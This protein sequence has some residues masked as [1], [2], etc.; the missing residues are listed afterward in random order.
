ME[1]EVYALTVF[2]NALIAG[3]SFGTAGGAPA[4]GIAS[5]NEVSWSPLGSGVEGALSALTVYDGKLIAGGEF[6]TAGTG[7]ARYI[8]SWNGSAWSPLGSGTNDYVGALTVY[9]NGLFVG[10]DFIIAG[11]KVSA[12]LAEWDPDPTGIDIDDAETKGLS[13]RQNYPNP[14][15]PGT[16]IAFT[17]PERARVT[18]AIY[19][20]SGRLVNTL[21]DDVVGRGRQQHAWNGRDAS[22]NPVS[23][24][25]Y[26]YRLTA[27]GRTLTKKMVMIR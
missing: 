12:F 20:V 11:G 10:G 24:G 6:M 15:N 23:S 26:F 19:D 5:W 13:L 16:T 8:A 27:G 7:A 4:Y 14:F 17:L 2:N 21:V 25:V 9:G 22:G 18:L 3:G 1:D